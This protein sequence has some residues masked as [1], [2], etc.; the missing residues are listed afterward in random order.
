MKVGRR[1]RVRAQRRNKRSNNTGPL[2][3]LEMADEA[4]ELMFNFSI[5]FFIFF[6][7]NLHI[8]FLSLLLS[9]KKRFCT[10]AELASANDVVPTAIFLLESSKH[11]AFEEGCACNLSF[12]SQAG[13]VE[14]DC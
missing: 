14:V 4:A 13:K 10:S 12:P 1:L 11:I 5:F 8:I 7:L 9:Y 6:F 2:L 3:V